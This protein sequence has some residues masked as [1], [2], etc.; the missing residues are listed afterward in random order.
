MLAKKDQATKKPIKLDALFYREWILFIFDHPIVSGKRKR[1]WYWDDEWDFEYQDGH[2]Q[3]DFVVRLFNRPRFLLNGYSDKKIEQGMW[4]LFSGREFLAKLLLDR[5]VSFADKR[6]LIRSIEELYKRLFRIREVGLCVNMFWDGLVCGVFDYKVPAKN[7]T[8]EKKRIQKEMFETLLKILAIRK[9]YIQ[10][11]A[12]HGL[13]H[14]QHPGTKRAVEDFLKRNPKMDA[15]RVN[16]ARQCIE[17][18]MM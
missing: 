4:F 14:L 12:L 5:R 2:G 10:L 17:G 3:V 18:E 11:A 6:R 1:E 7:L 13:G 15:Y 16:Y 9:D 8:S